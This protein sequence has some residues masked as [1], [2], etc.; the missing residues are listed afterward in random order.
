MKAKNEIIIN[1][2]VCVN[3]DLIFSSR[4]HLIFARE[5]G[6]FLCCL[7]CSLCGARVSYRDLSF[8]TVKRFAKVFHYII[9]SIIVTNLTQRR[10][11]WSIFLM[12]EMNLRLLGQILIN[13]TF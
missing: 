9:V 1:Y 12:V 7:L 4:K 13:A 11:D 8:R 5:K 2:K 10:T 6:F 3:T